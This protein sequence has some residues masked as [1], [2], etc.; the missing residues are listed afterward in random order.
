MQPKTLISYINIVLI[1]FILLFSLGACSVTPSRELFVNKAI[2]QGFQR[3]DIT[4]GQFN[5]FT[6]QHITDKTT[7]IRIYIEG[8]GRGWKTRNIPTNDPTPTEPLALE[9]ALQDPA[10]NIVYLARPCQYIMSP[11]CDKSLWTNARYSDVLINNMASA[12]KQI[13]GNQP[14]ELVGY[15][16]GGTVALLVAA[17]LP[18]LISIRT[19]AGNLDPAAHIKLHGLAPLTKSHNPAEFADQLSHIPQIH[20]VGTADENVPRAVAE[21]YQQQLGNTQQCSSIIDVPNAT[22]NTGWREIWLQLLKNVPVC[23]TTSS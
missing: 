17:Q 13:S 14:V 3:Q 23:H 1:I 8:D 2:I 22:H 19:V 15:S 7:P 12:I 16:G 4:A 9:L 10:L 20:F 5:L 18:N 6:L 11:V 21:S